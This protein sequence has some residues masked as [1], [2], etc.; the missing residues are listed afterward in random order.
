MRSLSSAQ[1]TAVLCVVSVLALLPALIDPA[2]VGLYYDNAPHLAEVQSLAAGDFLGHIVWDARLNT[3]EAVGQ[4][5]APLAW[6]S[7]AALERLG[8]GGL[9]AYITAILASNVVFTVGVQRLGER[10]SGER[11]VGLVAGLIAACSI[12]DLYGIAGAASG[13]W[14]HRLANGVFLLGWPLLFGKLDLRRV[15]GL[16][17]WLGAC[18]LLHTFTAVVALAC[19]GAVAVA[20]IRSEPKSAAWLLAAAAAAVLL[21]G[22]LLVPLLLEP[23]LRAVQAGLQVSPMDS[24]LLLT[25]PFEIDTWVGQG[26]LRLVGGPWGWAAICPLLLAPLGLWRARDRLAMPEMRLILLGVLGVILVG[27]VLFPYADFRLLGPNPWRHY[28]WLRV[29][30]ALLAGWALAPWIRSTLPL[31]GLSSLLLVP[32]LMAGQAELGGQRAIRGELQEAWAAVPE[33][34]GRVLH[35]DSYGR[36]DGPPG[37]S[38]SHAGAGLITAR[39]M[40][41]VGSWYTVS[42]NPAVGWTSTETGLLLGAVESEVADGWFEGRLKLFGVDRVLTVGEALRTRMRRLPSASEVYT[43]E[44]F[45]VFVLSADVMDWVGVPPPATSEVLSAEVQAAG[46]QRITAQIRTEGE[47]PFRARLGYHPW[48]RAELDGMAIPLEVGAENGL[49]QG[50]VPKDGVLTLAWEDRSRGWWGLSFGVL[51]VLLGVRLATR[52]LKSSSE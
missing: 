1:V 15:A 28:V 33:G 36:L 13:M 30:L 50:R 20:R 35:Q 40:S 49:V 14:P 31:I 16:A 44:H 46:S 27:A 21:A 43:S 42:P 4:L 37:L 25:V 38:R 32:T 18:S 2:A 39:G 5:N 3:G 6:M 8:I 9:W 34:P 29:L 26:T 41:V 19:V 10:L 47:S 12:T 52:R 17:L 51:L 23:S 22:G 11:V 7:L 48:W 45:S 24:L